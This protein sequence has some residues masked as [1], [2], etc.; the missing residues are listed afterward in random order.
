[1]GSA[2]RPAREVS[3]LLRSR[4]HGP[5]VGQPS[6]NQVLVL[7]RGFSGIAP[8]GEVVNAADA[9][10][11][12]V[13]GLVVEVLGNRARIIPSGSGKTRPVEPAALGTLLAD[14]GRLD[15][16]CTAPALLPG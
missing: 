5:A 1:M 16:A 2:G 6:G 15:R 12:A 14:F 8:G 7:G 11:P 9:D 10:Y 3:D 13:A 4:V